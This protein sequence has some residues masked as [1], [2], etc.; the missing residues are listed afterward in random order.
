[1]KTVS[2]QVPPCERSGL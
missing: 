1:M 2:V